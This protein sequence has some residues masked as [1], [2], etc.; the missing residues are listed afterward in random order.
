[1]IQDTSGQDNII[2]PAKTGRI[3]YVLFLFVFIALVFVAYNLATGNSADQSVKRSRLQIATLQ[4]GELVRDIL[5]SGKVIAANAP[6]IYAPV[7]G[8]VDLFVKAGDTVV[9]DQ[10]IARLESP[11]LETQLKQQSSELDSLKGEL[12]RK[13]LDARRQT[14][15]LTKPVSYTHLTLPT[16]YSV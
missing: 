9:I 11:E 1:M 8:Y 13:E 14:L 2:E 7:E 15:Q 6:Q 16:I 10:L 4:R 12:A 3:K 5:A